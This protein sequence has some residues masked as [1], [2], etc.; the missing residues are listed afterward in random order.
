MALI[1]LQTKIKADLKTCFD[2]SRNIDL[3]Q[4]SLSHSNEKAISGRTSGMIELGETVTWEAIHFGI[5]QR[6]T[7]KITEFNRPHYFVDEMVSGVFHSFRH[8]HIFTEQ[9]HYTLMIDKFHF[10]SPYGVLGKLVNVIFLK[11]YMTALLTTRNL[12]LQKE[13]ERIYEI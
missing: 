6:L 9:E 4:D 3:H 7:S 2:L 5:K 10:K 8:E 1:I 12:F 13:A 11:R